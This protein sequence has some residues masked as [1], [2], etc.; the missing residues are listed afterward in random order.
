MGRVNGHHETVIAGGRVWSRNGLVEADLGIDGGRIGHLGTRLDGSKRVNARNLWVLPGV[1]DG[2]THMEAAAFGLHSR[3]TFESGTRAAAAGGVTTILDFTAGSA[4]STLAEQ[5]QARVAAARRAVVDIGLHAEIVG[6]RSDRAYEIAEAVRMGV[7]SFKFYTVYA[8]RSNPS[9]LA[10]AFRVIAAAGGVAMVHAE[11]A[12]LIRTATEALPRGARQHMTS[13]PRSRPAA[14]EAAAVS[15]VCQLAEIAGVRVHFAHLS[16]GAAVDVVRSA[17]ARGLQVTAETCPHYLLLDERAY[18]TADGRQFSVIPPLRT[19]EDQSALWAALADGTI[20]SVATDHCPFVRP[21]KDHGDDVLS[22]P[23]GLP[24]V[25]TLLPL[26]H[27][28]G[29]VARALSLDWLV[30][31]LCASPARIFGLAPQKGQIE[32]GADADLVLFDPRR[33]WTLRASALHMGADFSP[34]E[35]R[36]VRGAVVRTLVRGRTVWADGECL[37]EPGWGRFVPRN[38]PL[39]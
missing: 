24:G 25:E 9:Q 26:L 11:D 3:D 23:C 37:V 29:V 20:D 6:W 14:S 4:E 8:E 19:P 35:G 30:R 32:V 18:A 12:D 33:A 7:T 34:Y 10:D 21:E 36:R 17:K 28:E 27:S 39:I 16:T 5:V 31:A 22:I 1:I 38:Q 13:F 15:L 2:H